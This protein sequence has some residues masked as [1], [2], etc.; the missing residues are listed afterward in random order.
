M[1]NY[2]SFS[3]YRPAVGGES[4]YCYGSYYAENKIKKFQNDA[5]QASDDT[6][7]LAVVLSVVPKVHSSRRPS[8]KPDRKWSSRVLGEERNGEEGD[9][10]VE[11]FSLLSLF[12]NLD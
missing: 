1:V 5:F 10:E 3:L 2:T 12:R 9:G 7:R 4:I 11:N 8:R 6:H